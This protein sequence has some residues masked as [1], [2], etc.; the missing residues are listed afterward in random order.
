[1]ALAPEPPLQIEE[2]EAATLLIGDDFTV[3]N[4]FLLEVPGLICQFRKLPG[5]A[6]QIA[7]ENF[8]SLCTAMK[9]RADTIEFVLQINCGLRSQRWPPISVCRVNKPLPHRFGARLRSSKHALD[10][11]KERQVCPMQ[12]FARSERCCLTDVA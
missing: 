9:L 12:L 3:N 10:R 1:V 11:T 4:H 6:P 5:N 7:G 8:N 2:G